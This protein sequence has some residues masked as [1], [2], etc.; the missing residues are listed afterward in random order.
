MNR[1]RFGALICVLLVSF[2]FTDAVTF[3][4]RESVWEALRWKW[5]NQDCNLSRGCAFP[6][7]GCTELCVL[8]SNICERVVRRP[9]VIPLADSIVVNAVAYSGILQ[10]AQVHHRPQTATKASNMAHLRL[11]HDMQCTYNV[12][13]RRVCVTIVALKKQVVL[14]ILSVCL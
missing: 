5:Q 2:C 9:V 6:M 11:K 12:T 3:V 1:A 13:L 14:R 4:T 8:R 10:A 7:F